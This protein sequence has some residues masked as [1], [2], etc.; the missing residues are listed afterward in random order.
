MSLAHSI[1]EPYFPPEHDAVVIPLWRPERLARPSTKDERQFGKLAA[2]TLGYIE[3]LYENGD[4]N[5][6]PMPKSNTPII[7]QTAESA[8]RRVRAE[9][10]GRMDYYGQVRPGASFLLTHAFEEQQ[11]TLRLESDGYRVVNG[12]Y[13]WQGAEGMRPAPD[14]DFGG[15]W[16]ANE[17]G[18]TPRGS[19]LLAGFKASVTNLA[20]DLKMFGVWNRNLSIVPPPIDSSYITSD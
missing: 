13:E 16:S 2:W 20:G 6:R 15:V 4:Y 9:A 11:E 8:P 14:A 18:V 1:G 3:Y 17:A 10:R 12:S 7:W 5:G 19:E